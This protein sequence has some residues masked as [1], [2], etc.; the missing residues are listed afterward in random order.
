[1]ET[2]QDLKIIDLVFTFTLT[3]CY[4]VMISFSQPYSFKIQ[5]DLLLFITGVVV[6]P[7]DGS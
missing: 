7:D 6:V 1:M 5:E 4:L 2:T 3:T